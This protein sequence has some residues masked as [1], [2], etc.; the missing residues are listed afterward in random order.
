MVVFASNQFGHFSS[1]NNLPAKTWQM[2]STR[3]TNPTE[4]DSGTPITPPIPHLAHLPCLSPE[5]S[6]FVWPR[7]QTKKW[8]AEGRQPSANPSAR[9]SG[10]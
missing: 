9:L 8:L 3:G 4:P 1:K 7:F 5:S 2:Q 6:C 10:L